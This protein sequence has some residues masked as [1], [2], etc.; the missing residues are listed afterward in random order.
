MET[1][2]INTI[3][4]LRSIQPSEWVLVVAGYIGIFCLW[5]LVGEPLFNWLHRETWL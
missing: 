4:Y 5:K 2:I 3:N 1:D